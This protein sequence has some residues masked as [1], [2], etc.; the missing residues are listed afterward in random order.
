MQNI[1]ILF[2]LL[3]VISCRPS[4]D[5]NAHTFKLNSSLKNGEL[6]LSVNDRTQLLKEE[7]DIMEF[8]PSADKKSIALEIEKL[9][10]S[11]SFKFGLMPAIRS[12]K[13]EVNM[14]VD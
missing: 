3:L 13:M 8:H 4:S 1:G 12:L 6:S 11:C 7:G 5:K 10:T 14:L 9:S 2:L